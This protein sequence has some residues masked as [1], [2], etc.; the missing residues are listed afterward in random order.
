MKK[1]LLLICLILITCTSVHSEQLK[2]I[3]VTDAHFDSSNEYSIKVLKSMV[4]DINNQNNIS[5]VVF[6]GDN[7]NRALEYDL[8]YFLNIVSSLKV[9]YYI[10]LG[11]HDVCKSTGLSKK[12]YYEIVKKH[13]SFYPQGTPNYLFKKDGFVFLIVDGS[14]EFIPGPSGYYVPDTLIWVDNCLAKYKNTPVI[15][16]QHYPIEYPEGSEGRADTHKT[17][18]AEDY[19]ALVNY[20]KNVVAIFSGHFHVNWEEMKN[21]VYHVSSPSLLSKPHAYKIV[22]VE[23]TEGSKPI[24]F[25]MLKNFEVK[26]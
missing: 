5:F 21:G 7:I 23:K 12:K 10:V 6:T 15:I 4:N 20:H 1:F 2:F 16:F 13:K 18:K 9:P 3:Q 8:K 19:R 22:E 11:N 17:Y 26:K 25:T 14:K 24:V